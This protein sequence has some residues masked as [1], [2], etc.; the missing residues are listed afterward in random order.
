VAH[1]GE[2]DDGE[3]MRISDVVPGG[4]AEVAGLAVGDRILA[5]DGKKIAT[6]QQLSVLLA[7]YKPGDEIPLTLERD[8]K[9]LE[10]PLTF[11]ERAGGGV[12]VGVSL[13]VVGEGGSETGS[14]GFSAEGC[15]AWI[16]D[17]YR[18]GEMAEAFGLDLT[19]QIEE[20]RACTDHDAQQM[21]KPIPQTWCDNVFK[22]HCS[23]LDLLA[24]I[25]DAQIAKCAAELSAS[26]GVDVSRNKAW[27]TCG[28]QK[29]FDRYSMRGEASDETTC[30]RILIEECGAEIED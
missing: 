26:L 15:L 18:A 10:L 27:N 7:S 6:Q 12:S 29:V 19:A 2:H 17:T 24:E 23:G 1:E 13:G 21:A 9:T 25:G 22:V 16:D 11:G 8:G 14:A 5:W 4:A 3:V 28:E 20:I 30:R